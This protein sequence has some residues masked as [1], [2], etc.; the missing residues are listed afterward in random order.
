MAV[1]SGLKSIN[2][3]EYTAQKLCTKI[4]SIKKLSLC[5]IF[6]TFISSMLITNDVALL[7]FIPFTIILLVNCKQEKH[8][9]YIIVLETI[10]A[11]LGSM[12]TP[13][14]NPQNL[15]LFSV[16]NISLLDFIKIL[17]PYTII[18]G[19]LLIVSIIPLKSKPIE[20]SENEKIKI[21]SKKELIVY[22][23]L[24]IICILTVLKIIPSYIT[25]LIILLSCL[26]FNRKVLQKIDYMLLLTFVAFFIFSNN[27]S[28]IDF[29]KNIISSIIEN[30]EC[31]TSLLASQIISNVPSCL[32]LYPF[33]QNL[34][35]L[36]IGVNLGGLGTIIASLASLISFKIY[37]GAKQD[38][39]DIKISSFNFLKI[40]TILNIIF[41][42]FL[43]IYKI[44]F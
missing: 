9:S 16:M 24:F 13:M 22:F 23:L 31:Y 28:K 42:V 5:L 15:F 2:F 32:L 25:C 36:L 20:I 4:K 39:P 19:I 10:A 3:F 14:G 27:I 17:L 35:E 29:I 7:S 18:S 6:L 41:L 26:I 38:Y 40:F 37:L 12:L 33:S 11:N 44:L 30:N 8:L 34:K 21:S 43:I 1:T